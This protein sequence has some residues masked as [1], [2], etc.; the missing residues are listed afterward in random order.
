MLKSILKKTFKGNNN[1]NENNNNNNNNGSNS[2]PASSSSSMIN[3]PRIM[4]LPNPKPLLFKHNPITDDYTVTDNSLGL[5]INGKVV[6]CFHKATGQK[7]AL[8]VSRL[9]CVLCFSL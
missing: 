4:S 3:V 6:E 8:K 9:L 5:G 1:R 2:D 7:Y